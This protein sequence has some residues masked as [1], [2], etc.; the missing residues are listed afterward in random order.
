MN[1]I[2]D[3]GTRVLLVVDANG[4]VHMALATCSLSVI[5]RRCGGQGAA[6]GVLH[7]GIALEDLLGNGGI[8]DALAAGD[9]QHIA[10]LDEVDYQGNEPA[11]EDGEQAADHAVPHVAQPEDG[12]GSVTQK[13]HSF[14]TEK[15]VKF[16]SS[17]IT[18]NLTTKLKTI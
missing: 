4:V 17:L 14:N 9:L 8:V 6:G 3:S 11:Q 13:L 12:P 16:L 18:F 1:S 15:Q 2:Q 5:H 10:S 7:L